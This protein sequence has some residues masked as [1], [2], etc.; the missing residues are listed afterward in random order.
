MLSVLLGL[1]L[2]LHLMTYQAGFSH[3]EQTLVAGVNH[4]RPVAVDWQYK[5]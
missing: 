5:A 4:S 1:S 3:L 2:S